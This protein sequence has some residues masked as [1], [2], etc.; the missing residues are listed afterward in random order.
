MDKKTVFPSFADKHQQQPHRRS[1]CV[2]HS[3]PACVV[4]PVAA[5]LE[6]WVD[7]QPELLVKLRAGLH[8]LRSPWPDVLPMHLRTAI[9]GWSS[10]CSIPVQRFARVD[11]FRVP[12]KSAFAKCRRRD[13]RRHV[14]SDQRRAVAGRQGGGSES[15]T[16]AYR[17]HGDRDASDS[18]LLY[19]RVLTGRASGCVG[20]SA[21]LPN[22]AS[23]RSAGTGGC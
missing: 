3:C 10:R 12:K 17:Q 14:A 7:Q 1:R 13:R 9:G 5:E 20:A 4:H 11:P 23:R 16:G 18:R 22:G 19:D 6:R 15:G 21:V 8:L 2:T